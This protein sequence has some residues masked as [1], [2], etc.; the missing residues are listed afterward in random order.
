GTWKD[1]VKVALG[2]GTP[3][4]WLIKAWPAGTAVEFRVGIEQWQEASS[5]QIVPCPL[6]IVE[7]TRV[8]RFGS[9]LEQD[10]ITRWRQQSAPFGQRLLQLGK[11]ETLVCTRIRWRC[12]ANSSWQESVA[13]SRCEPFQEVVTSHGYIQALLLMNQSFPQED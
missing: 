5:A 6:L 10:T 12:G 7:R 2:G 8:W 13:R 4:N 9:F 1:Q 3:G 11:L